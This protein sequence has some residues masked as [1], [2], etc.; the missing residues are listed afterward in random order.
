METAHF[1]ITDLRD[2]SVRDLDLPYDSRDMPGALP[3]DEPAD[4]G[5]VRVARGTIRAR[6]RNQRDYLQNIRSHD[7]TWT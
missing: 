5:S 1:L 7:L 3:V 4:A 2:R 6:G